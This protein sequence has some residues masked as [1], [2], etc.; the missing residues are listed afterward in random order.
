MPKL[1]STAPPHRYPHHF[2]EL[3]PIESPRPT[4]QTSSLCSL[5]SRGR[6][7]VELSSYLHAF[8]L[9]DLAGDSLNGARSDVDGKV[10]TPIETPEYRQGRRNGRIG[11][12]PN[13]DPRR[14]LPARCSHIS[15]Y[16]SARASATA[17]IAALCPAG[18]MST[19]V[20]D[21]LILRPPTRP[22]HAAASSN[23]CDPSQSSLCPSWHGRDVAPQQE[24]VALQIR[25]DG[26]PSRGNIMT[27]CCARSQ[28]TQQASMCSGLRTRCRGSAR[29]RCGCRSGTRRRLH[30]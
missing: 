18:V 29:S 19:S 7:G 30:A 24:A 17:S 28:L 2:K 16:A 4:Y 3:R 8:I 11:V 6:G 9:H 13:T 21:I 15:R 25:R 5:S 26:C 22:Q 27:Y 23:G 14:L 10:W 12:L 20:P 1:F